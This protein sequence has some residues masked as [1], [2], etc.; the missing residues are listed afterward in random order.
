[1]Q[2]FHHDTFFRWEPAAEVLHW[3]VRGTMSPATPPAPRR[4]VA[5]FRGVPAG[6][7]PKVLVPNTRLVLVPYPSP[8]SITSN[9][10]IRIV[11]AVVLA[12]VIYAVVGL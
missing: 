7:V 5:T 2:H 6:A 8:Y 12:V 1:M 11:L 3:R 10:S 4:F 9:N